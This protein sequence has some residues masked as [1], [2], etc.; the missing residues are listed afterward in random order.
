[1]R[2]VFIS[3]NPPHQKPMLNIIATAVADGRFTT[4]IA[5]ITQAGMVDTLSGSGPFT[6]FAPT[7][8]AFASLPAQTI[9]EWMQPARLTTLTAVLTL[10]VTAGYVSVASLQ[11][12]QPIQ[13]VNGQVL[14]GEWRNGVLHLNETSVLPT[15]LKA[16]NG[17]IY[18]LN[19]V[20]I[21]V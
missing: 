1:M 6:L 16:S 4:L 18:T 19:S 12:G 9:S 17:L 5:A 14:R 7:D 10:H 20:L 2:P 8:N 13:T 21:P 11:N 15:V 3:P